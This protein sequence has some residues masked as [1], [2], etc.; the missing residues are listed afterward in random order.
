V[1]S[2][3]SGPLALDETQHQGLAVGLRRRRITASTKVALPSARSADSRSSGSSGRRAA[4]R[5]GGE[6]AALRARAASQAPAPLAT[7]LIGAAAPG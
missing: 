7:E 3:I 6:T 2:A 1:R 5:A 4:L